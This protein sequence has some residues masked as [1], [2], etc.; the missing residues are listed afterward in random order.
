MAISSP[1]LART[2]LHHW[3][4]AHGAH[5]GDWD[6]WRVAECYTSIESETAA[7]RAGVGLCDISAFAKASL[8]GPGVSA[9]TRELAGDAAATRPLGVAAAGGLVL[10]C[11]LT[12]NHLLLLAS[13]TSP[14]SLEEHLA[15]SRG[16][17]GLIQNDVTAALAGC[18]LIGPATEDLLGRVTPLKM[19]AAGSCAE[20]SLAGVQ[21]LLVRPPATEL[22]S[23]QL[24]VAWDLVEYVWE[25]LLDAGRGLRLTPLGVASLRQLV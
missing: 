3:H 18:C 21:A 12:E 2:P 8:I 22:L 13:T 20:T 11:R 19:P 15:P 7:A 17:E 6:G 10:A 16:K 9:L 25:R 5:F 23:I 4:A 14:A 24:Y 1:P